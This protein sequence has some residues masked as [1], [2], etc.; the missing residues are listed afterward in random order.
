METGTRL[1]ALA[2]K[3][4]ERM[5]ALPD[6]PA[7]VDCLDYVA[8]AV[9]ALVKVREHKYWDRQGP[10]LK[11]YKARVVGHLRNIA[12]GNALNEYWI[13][14]FYFYSAVQRIAAAY[15]R[16]PRLLLRLPGTDRTNPHD[17]FRRIFGVDDRFPAWK[18]IY[19][20][21]NPLKHWP[22]GM[23]AGKKFSPDDAVIALQEIAS[24]LED[25]GSDL[26]ATYS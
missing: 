4:A 6:H 19:C 14:G 18:Q 10:F 8:G 16:L 9:F 26:Q 25:K 21:F 2:D 11:D 20:E 13:G 5:E 17:L 7:I 1:A 24:F 22:E 3:F 12:A 15:D 23:S